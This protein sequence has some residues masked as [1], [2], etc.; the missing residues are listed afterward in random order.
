MASMMWGTLLKELILPAF[1][2]ESSGGFTSFHL[3]PLP[4]FSS[5]KGKHLAVGNAV[6]LM[7]HIGIFMAFVQLPFHR[8]ISSL[9]VQ[10]RLWYFPGLY[11]KDRM[12]NSL[13]GL[14]GLA[15]WK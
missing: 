2:K 15:A 13:P 3:L 9:P 10:I 14:L 12:S 7:S 4:R 11:V 8:S 6:G 5:C 1:L